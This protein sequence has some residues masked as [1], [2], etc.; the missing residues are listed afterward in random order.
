MNTPSTLSVAL[1][2]GRLRVLVPKNSNVPIEKKDTVST[3]EDNASSVTI[4]IVYGDNMFI[5]DNIKLAEYIVDNIPPKPKWVP[6]IEISF[7]I[8]KD[9]VLR[10]KTTVLDNGYTREFEG[11]DLTN[12]VPPNRINPTPATYMEDLFAA[13]G[14]K[15]PAIKDDELSKFITRLGGDAQFRQLFF[16]SRDQAITG[17]NLDK[18]QVAALEII[19]PEIMNAVGRRSLLEQMQNIVNFKKSHPNAIRCAVCNGSGLKASF[20][21]N[22]GAAVWSAE[23]CESCNGV[24][25]V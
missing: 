21:R 3:L 10:V 19:T 22:A 18:E 12:I 16:T 5:G 17:Y 8:D 2:D 1:S 6:R 7:N 4:Q 11:I 9:L 20:E 14:M 24:G 25:F 23:K 13:F 15:Q